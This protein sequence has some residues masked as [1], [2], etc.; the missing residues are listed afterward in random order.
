V[1]LRRRGDV[2]AGAPSEASHAKV[3][4]AEHLTL[5]GGWASCH[6]QWHGFGL[7]PA[8]TMGIDHPLR[9]RDIALASCHDDDDDETTTTTLTTTT[10]PTTTDASL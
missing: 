5:R 3:Q 1:S 9:P 8:R 2:R 6:H 10:T 4:G 7:A